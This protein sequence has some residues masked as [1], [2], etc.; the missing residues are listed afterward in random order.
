MNWVDH[1]K[2]FMTISEYFNQFF[3]IFARENLFVSTVALLYT[4][5]D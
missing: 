4:T 3:A 5:S 1:P 2:D